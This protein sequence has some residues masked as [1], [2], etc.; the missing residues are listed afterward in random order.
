MDTSVVIMGLIITTLFITPFYFA[1][2]YGRKGNSSLVRLFNEEAHRQKITVSKL[3]LFGKKGFIIDAKTGTFLWC[4]SIDNRII[5]SRR[6]E[7]GNAVECRV[8]VNNQIWSDRGNSNQQITNVKIRFTFTRGEQMQES[9]TVFDFQSE[10]P[11]AAFDAIDFATKW[12][13]YLKPYL[14]K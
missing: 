5:D 9:V 6:I 14:T 7:I 11:M 12:C 10:D 2:R 4:D 13:G 3:G 1:F 8:L